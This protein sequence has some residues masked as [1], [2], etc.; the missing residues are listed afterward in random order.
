MVARWFCLYHIPLD[1]LSVERLT[2]V[3]RATLD[4]DTSTLK[5]SDLGVGITLTA[6]DDSTC[7]SLEPTRVDR[8]RA[9][10]YQ[11][12]PC[13]GQEAPRYQR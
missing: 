12:D 13:G 4:D 5:S 6:A 11:R 3:G 7:T 2:Q 10:T 1:E 9:E 8:L